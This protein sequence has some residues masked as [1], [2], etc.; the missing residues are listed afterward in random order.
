M[1]SIVGT[2]RRICVVLLSGEP[3]YVWK[4]HTSH[5]LGRPAHTVVLQTGR[6]TY[7]QWSLWQQHNNRASMLATGNS[8]LLNKILMNID[9]FI[10]IHFF[11]NSVTVKTFKTAA[12]SNFTY[13]IYNLVDFCSGHPWCNGSTS[14]IQYFSTQLKVSLFRTWRMH[15]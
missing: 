6:Q 9:K 7:V 10:V 15:V 1:T 5:L 11:K 4:T 13:I 8:S 2:D 12:K 14:N 3:P